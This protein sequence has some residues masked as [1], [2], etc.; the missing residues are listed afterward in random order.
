MNGQD[1][2]FDAIKAGVKAGRWD[3]VRHEAWIL[4]ELANVNIQ[5]AK[6][7]DYG[8]FAKDM[9]DRCVDLTRVLRKHNVDDAKKAISAVSQTCTTC[10]DR[11][12]KKND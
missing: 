5:Q 4:A 9:S 7:E 10:H 11:Y 3:D 12:R 6:E 8:K 2:V 1:V